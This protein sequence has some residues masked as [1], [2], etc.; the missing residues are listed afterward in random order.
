MITQRA[1]VLALTA[2]MA[3]CAATPLQVPQAAT[4]L[5]TRNAPPPECD[6]LKEVRGSQGNFWTAEF[7]SDE[8]LVVGARNKMRDAAYQLGANY[9]QIELEKQSHNTTDDSLGGTYSSVIIG[10]AYACPRAASA[11]VVE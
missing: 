4:I 10:N 3:G 6:F 5:V 9:V 2:A 7:T 11:V 1:L 8:D